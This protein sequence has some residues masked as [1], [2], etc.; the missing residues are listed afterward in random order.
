MAITKIDSSMYEDV[1]GANNLVKLDANAKIPA[2]AATNLTNLPGPEKSSSD[3]TV[4]SNKAVGTQ[5]LNTSSGEMYVCTDATAGAN[6]WTNVGAGTGDIVPWLGGWTTG[7]QYGYAMGGY[8]PSAATDTIQKYSF[9]SDG[10]STDV[11]NLTSARAHDFSGCSSSTYGYANGGGPPASPSTASNV[12]DKHQ[13]GTS[14]NST[15]VGDLTLA[16]YASASCE[17][18]SY[19]YVMG[20]AT[21]TKQNIIERYPF[22]SDTN[23]SDVGDLTQNLAYCC[24][25]ASGTHGYTHGGNDGAPSAYGTDKIEKFALAS[26]ANSTLYSGVIL[27]TY[28]NTYGGGTGSRTHGYTYG[29]W[30]YDG[31]SPVTAFRDTIDKFSYATEANATDVGNLVVARARGSASSSTTHGYAAGGRS[32]DG[33]TFF[34]HLEKHSFASDGNATDVGDMLVVITEAAGNQY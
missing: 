34:N 14:N 9:T 31:S 16:R 8:I 25:S 4:S 5:W 15:D 28:T 24:G 22:A 29:R 20:G 13:Y 27:G 26:S 3:P 21:P 2:G 17:G 6:V 10:N 33:N 1:S 23:A 11:A 19:G 7:T 30:A 18:S 32:A 12:I